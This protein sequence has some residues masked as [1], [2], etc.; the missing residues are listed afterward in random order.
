MAAEQV[1]AAERSA[2]GVADDVVSED[3]V[4]AEGAGVEDMSVVVVSGA[5][6]GEGSA[7]VAG[8]A[9]FA[10]LLFGALIGGEA[11]MLGRDAARAGFGSTWWSRWRL[12]AARW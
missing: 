6:Q 10:F 9:R 12:R 8:V 4:E 11:A 1:G 7:G 3:G 5:G 2:E